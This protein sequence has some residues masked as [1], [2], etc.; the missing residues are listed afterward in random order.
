MLSF[1]KENS[2]T[3]DTQLTELSNSE[4]VYK[5]EFDA[6]RSVH[7]QFFV[8]VGCVKCKYD[9]LEWREMRGGIYSTMKCIGAFIIDL[10]SQITDGVT[11]VLADLGISDAT[12]IC[13][14]LI[15]LL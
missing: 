8:K 13:S 3:P 5:T 7:L 4:T 11:G 6:P 15:L 14:V 2:I 1:S 10:P 9:Y 12:L